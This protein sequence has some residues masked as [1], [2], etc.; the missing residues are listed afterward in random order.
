MA[1]RLPV[2]FADSEYETHVQ[3]S[4][5]QEVAEREASPEAV[6]ADNRF[7]QRKDIF[8][9]TLNAFGSELGRLARW[10][11]EQIG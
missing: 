9:A 6:C 10:C 3:I 7:G 1:C 8:A 5:A 2:H 11:V 4:F